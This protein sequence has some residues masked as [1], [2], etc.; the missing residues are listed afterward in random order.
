MRDWPERFA[1]AQ[2]AEA[3]VRQQ[4]FLADPLTPHLLD[5]LDPRP[6]ERVLDV[7]T[8]AG[9]IAVAAAKA[10]GEGGKVVAVDISPHLVRYVNGRAETEELSQLTA[11][12]ADATTATFPGGPFDA[13]T[14]QMGVMFFADPVAAFANVRR[15]LAPGGRFVFA[16]WATSDD[17]PLHP[18]ILARLDQLRDEWPQT[19]EEG[20]FS[21]VDVHRTRALLASAGY[22]AIER[23]RM[24]IRV[25]VSEETVLDPYVVGAAG[26][27]TARAL[28]RERVAGYRV[29]GGVRAPLAVQIYSARNPG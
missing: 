28:V 9:P 23:R 25:T 22:V 12:E 24:D 11:V 4:P 2:W 10:V 3:W 8:G 5:A 18:D 27:E 29:E 14:S 6:G 21:L 16:C 20:P 1:D 15:Q 13:A 7:G 19:A 17:N 26:N